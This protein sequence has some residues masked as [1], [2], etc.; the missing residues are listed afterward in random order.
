MNRGDGQRGFTLVETLTVLVIFAVTSMI[1]LP[2]LGRLLQHY[3]LSNA[4]N[5][6]A[7]EI[8]R[9]RMQAVAQNRAVRVRAEAD[10]H[11][12]CRQ[13]R[14]TTSGQWAPATC[15]EAT[16]FINLSGETVVTG[17]FPEFDRTGQA[18]SAV[19]LVVQN[20]AGQMRIRVGILGRVSLS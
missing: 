10:T 3:R 6:V 18:N 16:D 8:G 17:T 1:A 13:F 2:S 19:T 7:F 12:V 15:S 5:Q 4:T 11:Q 14:N 20:S 9:A